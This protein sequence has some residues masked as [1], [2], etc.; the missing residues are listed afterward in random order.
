M[1]S[2]TG[3]PAVK[4]RAE[5][6][7]GEITRR[8]IRS[9]GM[10]AAAATIAL[11][12][13]ACET[14]TIVCPGARPPGR[15]RRPWRAPT[16][17]RRTPRR[18]S[19]TRRASAGRWAIPASCTAG[20]AASRS[21]R[22]RRPRSRPGA[23]RTRRPSARAMGAAVSRVRSSGDAYTAVGAL[24]RAAMRSAAASACAWPFSERWRPRGLA[25]EHLA[26]G[27]GDAVAHQQHDGRRGSLAAAPGGVRAEA[28]RTDGGTGAHR[29]LCAVASNRVPS[30]LRGRGAAGR[31]GV[32]ALP[33]AGA[34]GARRWHDGPG[35]VRGPG[36]LGPRRPGF[37]DPDASLVHRRPGTG[38]ARRQPH[39]PDVHRGPIGRLALR[40]PAPGRLRVAADEHLAA[41]TASSC[42]DAYITPAVH[43]AP[44]ANKP[45]AGGADGV[46]AVSGPGAVPPARRRR[47]WWH[48][49]SSPGRRSAPT[50]GCG[51]ARRSATWPR[52]LP[53]GVT[54]LGS[55]HPSQQNTFTGKLTVPMFD[56]VFTRARAAHRRGRVRRRG[57]RAAGRSGC[58]PGRG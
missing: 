46:H 58:G 5:I 52:P 17:R 36:L 55:Y 33:A 49:G 12:G 8:C 4:R 50:T 30:G 35:V 29:R 53:D 43:C 6:E 23:V 11:I 57:R 24:A 28:D 21:T 40:R 44:P 51:R 18:G 39:G 34:A 27:R 1:H 45:D 2:T 3:P 16:S 9:S 10:P 7:Q 22:P 41:T 37:G 38:G 20:P 25:G 56:A 14:A 13:S 32:P 48:W 26:G 42:T 47:S 54:L 19:G 31:G 15:A